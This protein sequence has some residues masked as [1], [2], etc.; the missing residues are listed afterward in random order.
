MKVLVVKVVCRRCGG[1]MGP[2]PLDGKLYVCSTCGWLIFSPD[3]EQTKRIRWSR[4]L[5][6]PCD[7]CTECCKSE[8]LILHPELGDRPGDYQTDLVQVTGGVAH[9]LKQKENGDCI[10]LGERG[11]TIHGR[12]PT[13]CRSLDCRIWA[14]F[15]QREVED[16]IA[17]RILS[18]KKV[19]AAYGL[20]ER[21]GPYPGH[22]CEAVG[23]VVAGPR[24]ACSLCQQKE[25]RQDG[26]P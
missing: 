10:Y 2:L 21:I 25:A 14:L 11:C 3:D 24:D 4:G 20:A 6:L 15:S 16:L 9:M 7:G 12:H 17:K 5:D 13:M 19:I 26:Q 23:K 8:N 22:L 1:L 18:E